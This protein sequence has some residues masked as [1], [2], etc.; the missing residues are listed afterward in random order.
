[1]TNA[2]VETLWPRLQLIMRVFA[3]K[4]RATESR[5]TDSSAYNS[6]DAVENWLREFEQFLNDNALAVS[7]AVAQL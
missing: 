3:Q 7:K 2:A 1:M 4:L 6:N 5:L